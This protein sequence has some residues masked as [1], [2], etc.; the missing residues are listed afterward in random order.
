MLLGS[1]L[2]QSTFA[3]NLGFVAGGALQL[4][5]C[6]GQRG[7]HWHARGTPEA[8]ARC[9]L[10]F[11]LA[12][13][14]KVVTGRRLLQHLPPQNIAAHRVPVP[15]RGF[16]QFFTDTEDPSASASGE[17]DGTPEFYFEAATDGNGPLV[18]AQQP[19]ERA[20]PLLDRL[21]RGHDPGAPVPRN[22]LSPD[23]PDRTMI[24]GY[25]G[26]TDFL[27]R[28]MIAECTAERQTELRLSGSGMYYSQ[29]R[30]GAAEIP[31]PAAV[32]EVTDDR[33]DADRLS[34]RPARPHNL[35]TVHTAEELKHVGV[36][37]GTAAAAVNPT[38]SRAATED[39]ASILG[40]TATAD[41]TSLH[42]WEVQRIGHY[43]AMCRVILLIIMLF[44]AT[45][46]VPSA[47]SSVTIAFTA[48]HE[49]LRTTERPF[50]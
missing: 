11:S 19:A 8:N 28:A 47:M 34:G 13:L 46:P 48:R 40:G 24:P 20:A 9:G 21:I 45:G 1:G 33:A 25:A 16:L 22:C 39:P 37:G 42:T 17:R 31:F 15:R 50:L 36:L 38:A 2:A 41:D 49:R 44:T 43:C 14:G 3:A 23:R 30:K 18:A 29:G 26:P 12:P 5:G 4:R 35:F 7:W 6:S 32:R 27:D 10:E